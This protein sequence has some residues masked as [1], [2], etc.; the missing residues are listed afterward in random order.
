[1]AQTTKKSWNSLTKDERKK[2]KLAFFD[3]IMDLKLK[4]DKEKGPLKK[5]SNHV[6][7]MKRKMDDGL[8]NDELFGPEVFDTIL[9]Y[10]DKETGKVTSIVFD[11][12]QSWN[13][14]LIEILCLLTNTQLRDDD[15]FTTNR[16]Y[17]L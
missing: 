9:F 14:E 6:A 11:P 3:F 7:Y 17:T 10:F 5:L 12:I 16:T 8:Y 1:M 13:A 4:S 15:G 2:Q